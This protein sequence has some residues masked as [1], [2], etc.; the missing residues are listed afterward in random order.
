[1]KII[2]S[3]AVLFAAAFFGGKYALKNTGV[4]WN[5]MWKKYQ[6]ELRKEESYLLVKSEFNSNTAIFDGTFNNWNDA[7]INTHRVIYLS[8]T[9]NGKISNEDLNKRLSGTEKIKIEGNLKTDDG[10]AGISKAVVYYGKHNYEV[11]FTDLPFYNSP[12]DALYETGGILTVDLTVTGNKILKQNLL[13]TGKII[14]GKE[15]VLEVQDGTTL[16]TAHT[17]VNG[18]LKGFVTGYVFMKDNSVFNGSLL[19][20]RMSVS[21][22][23][24]MIGMFIGEQLKVDDNSELLMKE[25]GGLFTSADL[26]KNVTLKFHDGEPLF[27]GVNAN[28]WTVDEGES[29]STGPNL[30]G[31]NTTGNSWYISYTKT[32]TDMLGRKWA[33]SLNGKGALRAGI[34]GLGYVK[35]EPDLKLELVGGTEH[36][37]AL[38]IMNKYPIVNVKGNVEAYVNEGIACPPNDAQV[39]KLSKLIKRDAKIKTFDVDFS[40]SAPNYEF[41]SSEKI[42]VHKVMMPLLKKAAKEVSDFSW[43]SAKTEAG[44]VFYGYTGDQTNHWTGPTGGE[45]CIVYVNKK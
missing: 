10:K 32:P 30:A 44:Y 28:E 45:E 4:V 41:L 12:T 8:Q 15:A 22:N 6:S 3:V 14:I 42:A 25:F 39:I 24:T 26:G 38:M 23:S 7:N 5:I 9:E 36:N 29:T 31:E 35:N 21:G 1:M 34:D 43:K 16:V 17:E 33:G 11:V 37:F 27:L 20:G 2:I 40:L 18:T 13:S 19:L